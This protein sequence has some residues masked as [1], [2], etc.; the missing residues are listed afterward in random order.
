MSA[1]TIQYENAVHFPPRFRPPTNKR[2][3]TRAAKSMT[4]AAGFRCQGGVVLC[5]DTEI[6]LGLGKTYQSKLFT[7]SHRLGCYMTYCGSADFAKELVGDLR[8]KLDQLSADQALPIIR[9][10]YRESFTRACDPKD[11][12]TW[13]SVLITLRHKTGRKH[14]VSLYTGRGQHFAPEYKYA[15]L[16]IG[17]DQSEALFNWLYMDEMTVSDAIYMVVYALRLVKEFVPGCGGETEYAEVF[18]D[19]NSF[20]LGIFIAPA[21]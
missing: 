21:S 2:V 4:I 18:D 5:A 12:S 14:R 1:N 3:E 7:I 17:Q 11:E 20:A 10:A 19:E 16:G 13:T 6:T 15:T 8:P 9:D